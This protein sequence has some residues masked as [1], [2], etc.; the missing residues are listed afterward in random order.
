MSNQSVDF[1]QK[2]LHFRCGSGKDAKIFIKFSIKENDKVN[3]YN[4]PLLTLNSIQLF[5]SKPKAARYCFGNPNPV[6][7]STGIRNV[8]GFITASVLNESIGAR[9]RG[10]LKNY[11][12][13]TA[14]S[15]DLDID[16]TLT[17]EE[18][19]KLTNLDQLPSC[20]INI[21][22]TNPETGRIYSKSVYGV[23][24]T[25]ESNSL[26]SSST[27]LESFSFMA[28]DTNELKPEE[29]SQD[30]SSD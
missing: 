26:G 9:L 28:E 3:I 13:V 12:P 23:V 2:S 10:I 30:N 4:I 15:L 1:A 19:D 27:M 8:Q 7:L 16:G 20:Q 17:I 22:I 18:L 6:G 29:I 21:F 14:D 25:D 11:K 5:T 24:F